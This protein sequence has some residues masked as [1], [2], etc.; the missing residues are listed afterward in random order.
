MIEFELTHSNN[1]NVCPDVISWS[2][3]KV[4]AIF[5]QV[6]SLGSA[7]PG[8]VQHRAQHLSTCHTADVFSCSS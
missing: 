7:F 3:D 8:H 4:V 5:L 6:S 2:E 1:I